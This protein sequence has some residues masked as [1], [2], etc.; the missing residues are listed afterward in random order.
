MKT[1]TATGIDTDNTTESDEIT[2][3]FRHVFG[4]QKGLLQ[5]WAGVRY[6]KDIPEETIRFQ[7]FTYPAAAATAAEWALKKSEEGREVYFCV[8]LL[9]APRRIKDNAAEVI[10]LWGEQDGTELPNVGLKPSAVVESSPGHYH[11]YWRLTDAVPPKEA[12][13]LNKRLA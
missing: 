12:E 4:D 3:F 1:Q 2:R 13:Q 8:H 9:T 5:I 10:A 7:N 6:G 11:L